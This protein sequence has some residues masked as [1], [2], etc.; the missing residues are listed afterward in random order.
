MPDMKL[1]C[2]SNPCRE[3]PPWPAT[4]KATQGLLR[5]IEAYPSLIFLDMLR[6][7]KVTNM[8]YVQMT[9]DKIRIEST[10]EGYSCLHCP[11]FQRHVS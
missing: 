3:D 4:T 5:M 11:Q 2:K 10:L 1:V 6:D 8:E 7:L 9:E